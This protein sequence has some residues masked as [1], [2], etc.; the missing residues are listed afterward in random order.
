MKLMLLS[1]FYYF[2]AKCCLQ[3]LFI[4]VITHCF[5]NNSQQTVFGKNFLKIPLAVKTAH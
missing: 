3:V 4:T 1:F 2:N 5:T